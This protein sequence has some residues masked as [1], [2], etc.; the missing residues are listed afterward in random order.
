M[1]YYLMLFKNGS[2]KIYKNKQSPGRMEEGVRQFSCS[3]NVTVQDL[4]TW[5]ANGYKKLNTVRE[6]ER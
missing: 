4:Y 3:S 2:F 5:A 1:E 6:I